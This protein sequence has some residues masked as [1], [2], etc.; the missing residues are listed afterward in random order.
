M[1]TKGKREFR[2]WKWTIS[3]YA[4]EIWGAADLDII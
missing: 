2:S 4:Y 3:I 1:L